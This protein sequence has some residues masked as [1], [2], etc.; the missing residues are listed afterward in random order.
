LAIK[1]ALKDVAPEPVLVVGLGGSMREGSAT[2][3]ALDVA[4]AAAEAAGARTL[5]LGARVLSALPLYGADPDRRSREAQEM[6]AAL[7]QADGLIIAS[8]AYHGSVSG[9]VKNAIDYIEDT[10]QDVRPYLDGVPV[11]LIA[12]AA[13]WQAAGPT[14]ASL[15]AIVHALRGWPTPLGVGVNT[16]H[17]RF[18]TGGCSDEATMAQLQL[19]GRQTADFAARNRAL[20]LRAMARAAMPAG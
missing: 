16:S 14:L 5:R 2:E 11:G 18:E 6:L 12:T 20:C 9:A 13:G 17:A 1:F 19:V 4:L 7:R 8:P 3:Q 15:R 10:R